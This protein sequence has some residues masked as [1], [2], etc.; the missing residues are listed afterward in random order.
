VGVGHFWYFEDAD[1]HEKSL[2]K[3]YFRMADPDFTLKPVYAAMKAY[4]SQAPVMYPGHY[5]EDHWAVQWDGTWSMQTGEGY[6]LGAA[7]V[8][9][10]SG[11]SFS[12]VF[13]GTDL[14][15]VT[16]R[17]PDTGKLEVQIDGGAAK[18][19]DLSAPQ[20]STQVLAPV[21]VTLAH[22][23]PDSLHH[24]LVTNEAGYKVVDGFVVRRGS[25]ATGLVIVIAAFVLTLGA[26][27]VVVRR[28]AAPRS[29]D[30][31]HQS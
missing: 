10:Q 25:N 16:R 11:G 13:A 17:L 3:Y 23:L 15:L 4:T 9:P 27:W 1:D 28:L 24:V 8:S 19:M 20:D 18:V 14:D 6:E 22:G 2:A 31:I 30:G 5:Q 7:R 29:H 21:M 12:F 26:S